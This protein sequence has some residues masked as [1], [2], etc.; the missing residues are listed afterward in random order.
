MFA[1]ARGA[2]FR[3]NEERNRGLG[4]GGNISLLERDLGG[5]KDW[6]VPL[7]YFHRKR[8]LTVGSA[9]LWGKRAQLIKRRKRTPVGV[10]NKYGVEGGV[11]LGGLVR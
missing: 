9:S 6:K 10:S 7:G 3:E 8:K 1:N 4:K 11:P 5:K 2:P